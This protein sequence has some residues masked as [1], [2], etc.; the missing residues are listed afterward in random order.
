[1]TAAS[2]MV[3]ACFVGAMAAPASAL[4]DRQFFKPAGALCTA[5]GGAYGK[6]EWAFSSALNVYLCGAGGG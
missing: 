5:Q 4:S 2:V 3:A 1:M 6:F